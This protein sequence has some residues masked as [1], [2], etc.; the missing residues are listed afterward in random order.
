MTLIEGEGWIKVKK[1][2]MDIEKFLLLEI[3]RLRMYSFG[4]SFPFA[5]YSFY[6]R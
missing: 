3:V 6:R 2:I 4:V 1:K 5:Y